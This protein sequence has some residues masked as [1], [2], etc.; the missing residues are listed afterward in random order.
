M[1]SGGYL[2]STVGVEPEGQGYL[3]YSIPSHSL[4][5]GSR[6]HVTDAMAVELG[7]LQVIYETD[8]NA[9][10]TLEYQKG[11]S[12]MVVGLDYAW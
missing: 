10:G 5:V 6:I 4:A 11:A 2:F 7:I 8:Q 12:G 9:A 1:I 3:T